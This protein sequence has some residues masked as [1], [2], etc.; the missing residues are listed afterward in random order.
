MFKGFVAVWGVSDR[1]KY[2]RYQVGR[3]YCSHQVDDSCYTSVSLRHSKVQM[4][5][6]NIFQSSPSFW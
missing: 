6:I 1:L 3:R 2:L 4:D 5:V